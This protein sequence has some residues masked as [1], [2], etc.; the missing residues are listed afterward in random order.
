MAMEAGQDYRETPNV[1]AIES[2]VAVP[3]TEVLEQPRLT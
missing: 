1:I 3:K 2:K